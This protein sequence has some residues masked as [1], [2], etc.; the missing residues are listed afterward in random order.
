LIVKSKDKLWLAKNIDEIIFNA[1]FLY[2]W[3]FTERLILDNQDNKD[4]KNERL[5]DQGSW[6]DEKKE[7][8]DLRV[9]INKIFDLLNSIKIKLSN[10]E[11]SVEEAIKKI[12]FIDNNNFNKKISKWES[13][14][15][16]VNLKEG[17]EYVSKNDIIDWIDKY[18]KEILNQQFLYPEQIEAANKTLQIVNQ[19][20]KP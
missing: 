7:K 9:I 15:R 13:N 8:N 18:T 5:D 4:E 6:N 20:D 2:N 3:R 1:L 14:F 16:I 11:I 12:E 17:W 19:K 10:W